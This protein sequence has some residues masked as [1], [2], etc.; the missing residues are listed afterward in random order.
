MARVKIRKK[1]ENKKKLVSEEVGW[2]LEVGR[3]HR[4]EERLPWSELSVEHPHER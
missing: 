4:L 2:L 3:Y 1:R